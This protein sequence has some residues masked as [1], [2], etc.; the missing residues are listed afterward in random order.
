MT[1]ALPTRP[2]KPAWI[3]RKNVYHY[4]HPDPAIDQRFSI[5]RFF[6]QRKAPYF[7]VH[8]T[9]SKALGIFD[10]LSKAKKTIEKQIA[11]E[12]ENPNIRTDVTNDIARGDMAKAFM[13]IIDYI[14]KS[15]NEVRGSIELDFDTLR[16]NLG[17]I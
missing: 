5:K 13:R 3:R 7:A 2:S 4:L 10:R 9:L 6:D 16:R 1:A 12:I 11:W 8:D 15:D 17:N 14:D